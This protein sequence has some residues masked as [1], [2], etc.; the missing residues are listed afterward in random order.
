MWKGSFGNR[1]SS[2]VNKGRR[3]EDDNKPLDAKDDLRSLG[4][5]GDFVSERGDPIDVKS[6]FPL[7][8][9]VIKVGHDSGSRIAIPSCSGDVRSSS[10]NKGLLEPN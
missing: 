2:V 6:C 7:A 8:S 3:D 9:K 1:E 4:S 5:K 10:T